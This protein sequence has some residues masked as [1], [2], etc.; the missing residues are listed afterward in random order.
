[1]ANSVP[2]E[3]CCPACVERLQHL[4]I[5][6]YILELRPGASLSQVKTAYRDLAKVWHPDR[7]DGDERIKAKAHDRFSAINTAYRAL[8]AEERMLRFLEY[9]VPSDREWP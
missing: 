9:Y 7:F 5:C 6:L 8:C 1:M 3:I 4:V 2:E